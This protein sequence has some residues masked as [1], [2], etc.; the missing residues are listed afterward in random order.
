[1]AEK[2]PSLT[3]QSLPLELRHHILRLSPD[4]PSLRSL[5]LT[6]SAFYNAFAA[7][8]QATTTAVLSRHIHPHVQREAIVALAAARL[9]VRHSL[10]LPAFVEANLIR[11]DTTSSQPEWSLADALAAYRVH[12]HVGYLSQ[13][14]SRQLLD[15][16]PFQAANIEHDCGGAD[17]STEMPLPRPSNSELHRFERSLYRFEICCSL[18]KL[19]SSEDDGI[20]DSWFPKLPKFELEQLSCVNNLL[21]YL[22]A[23]AFND[24]VQHDVSW[25]YFGID[26]I[27][28]ESSPL[29]QRVLSRGLETLHALVQA[30]T[31]DE[32]RRILHGGDNREDE[33]VGASDFL[34]ER[35]E[36]TPDVTLA[37]YLPISELLPDEKARVLGIPTYPDIP[38]DAGPAKIFE[39]VHRDS[40]PSELVA[41]PEFRSYQRWGYVFWDEARLEKLGALIEDGPAKLVTPP[42]PLQVY[43]ELANDQLQASRTRRSEIWRRGGSGWWSQ[44]DESKVVWPDRKKKG[45]H[46]KGPLMTA[47]SVQGAKDFLRGLKLPDMRAGKAEG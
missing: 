18:Y 25:G 30:Q 45:A 14:L 36:R 15:R 39:L 8:E 33:P 13:A 21:T 16:P 42:N 41:Q 37:T 34:C 23:P 11:K 31:F 2:A 43:G 27:T 6:C 5:A 17:Q 12:T 35:L 24:L 32:R 4:P 3:I 46:K 9:P 40:F 29:A 47:R 28:D 10:A 20:W 26:L 7:T 22:I 19:S 38:G 1:M 44:D